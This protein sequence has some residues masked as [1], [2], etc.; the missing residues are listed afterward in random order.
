ME[1]FKNKVVV[2]TGSGFGLGK[3]YAE[4]FAQRGAR[5]AIVDMNPEKTTATVDEIRKA[6][7]AV[8]GWSVD[9]SDEA[10]VNK[11]ANEI[12]AKLGTVDIL[13]NNAGGAL[14]V[15]GPVESFT[16][17]QWQRILDVNISGTWYCTRA[18]LAGMKKKSWGRI[19]NISST[20]V[21]QAIPK[22]MV[23]YMTV[24]AA[25]IGLTSGLGAE[26]GPFGI[27]CN[28]IAPGLFLF[29]K[30]E[31]HNAEWEKNIKMITDTVWAQQA[32]P[33]RGVTDDIV[34]AV[35]F[36]ASEAAGFITG[37]VLK[38]DGGWVKH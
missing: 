18:F 11:M 6:G 34:G 10:A 24:K 30:V 9:V 29:D 31:H 12:A 22:G 36:L 37:Q 3:A 32:I 28:A 33:R 14:R 13:V 17:A 5:V 1:D 21:F 2:V 19:I 38:V 15:P 25:V 35:G 20:T 26:L 4:W 7:G 16:T 27:T 23:P 8:E